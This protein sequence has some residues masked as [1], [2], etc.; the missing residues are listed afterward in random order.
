M[1]RLSG[2]SCWLALFPLFVQVTYHRLSLSEPNGP[3]PRRNAHGGSENKVPRDDLS[4]DSASSRGQNQVHSFG[5]TKAR[6]LA[7][8]VR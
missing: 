8:M 3:P 5:S 1:R 6:V 2:P 7:D 4:V